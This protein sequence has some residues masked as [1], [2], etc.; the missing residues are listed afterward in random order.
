MTEQDPGYSAGSSYAAAQIDALLDIRRGLAELTEAVLLV[1]SVNAYR[2]GMSPPL[3]RQ[4]GEALRAARA[5]LDASRENGPQ[6]HE[7][8]RQGAAGA[9]DG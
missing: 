7:A 8:G 5:R 2:P 9:S 6:T 1:A 4:V 3:E